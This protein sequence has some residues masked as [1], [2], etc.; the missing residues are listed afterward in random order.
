MESS[1]SLDVLKILSIEDVFAAILGDNTNTIIID[2]ADVV[3]NACSGLW[4]VIY[5]DIKND[6]QLISR[7]NTIRADISDFAALKYEDDSLLCNAFLIFLRCV[8]SIPNIVQ[9]KNNYYN[10]RIVC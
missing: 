6:Y 4:D 10:T 5:K 1:L 2:E 7:S 9:L 8:L 3:F